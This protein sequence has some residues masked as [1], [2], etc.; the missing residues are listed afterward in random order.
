[1]ANDGQFSHSAYLHRSSS[2]VVQPIGT[3]LIWERPDPSIIRTVVPS[4]SCELSHVLC[5]GLGS[6]PVGEGLNCR[7]TSC[8]FFVN[9]LNVSRRDFIQP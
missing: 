3:V 4:E 1:M 5:P 9:L 2:F 7:L 8:C 6:R